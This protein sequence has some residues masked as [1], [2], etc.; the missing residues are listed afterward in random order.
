MK[1][2]RPHLKFPVQRGADGGL[3]W[4]E[5]GSEEQVLSCATL[6][7]RTPIGYR[8]ERP[9]F[10]WDWPDLRLAPIDVTPLVNA[11]NAFEP[12]AVA[13]LREDQIQQLAD[14]ASGVQNLTVELGMQTADST[15]VNEEN[16]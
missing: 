2:L 8:D 13:V 5:Q 3:V 4:Q 11:L 12:R 1:P 7:A 9:E 16:D 10:G 14:A 15:G 6:I